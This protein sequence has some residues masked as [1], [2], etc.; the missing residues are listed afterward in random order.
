MAANIRTLYAYNFGEKVHENDNGQDWWQLEREKADMKKK[1][2][3]AVLMMSMVV[4]SSLTVC[5]APEIMA[6]GTVFDAEYYVQMYLD[7]VAELGT[8]TDALYQQNAI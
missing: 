1:I 5:A 4:G 8:D 6:D 3:A 2:M 7:G